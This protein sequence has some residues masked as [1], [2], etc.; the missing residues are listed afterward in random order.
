MEGEDSRGMGK[1][2]D[3]EGKERSDGKGWGIGKGGPQGSLG[4]A[5][6]VQG[7]GWMV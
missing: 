2:R 7:T 1:D 5:I 6:G 3:R 4:I